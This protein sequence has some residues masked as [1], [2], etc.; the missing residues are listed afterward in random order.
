MHTIRR[1]FVLLIVFLH[2]ILPGQIL[3]IQSD[4]LWFPPT[5]YGDTLTG[6][7]TIVN[8]STTAIQLK[9]VEIGKA[10][11]DLAFT[12]SNIPTSIPPG[13]SQLIVRFHPLNDIYYRVP[14]ILRTES[15]GGD[16]TVLLTGQGKFFS[17]IG[18]FTENKT[19]LALKQALASYQS[20]HT[21]L[22]YNGARDLM[23]SKLDNING[24]VTCLYTGRM[25]QFNTRAGATA[26]NF[27]AEHVFPQSFFNQNEPMRSDL[28]HLYSTDETAN[29]I[30]SNYPYGIITG[31]PSWQNN[32][33]KLQNGVFEPR[34]SAKGRVAR[35]LLYFVVRYQDYS[36]FV[37]PQ[38][39]LLRNWH[40]QHLPDAMD[41]R[42]DSI[43]AVHQG[44]HNVFIKYPF[45]LHRINSLTGQA[46]FP[47]TKNFRWSSDTLFTKTSFTSTYFSLWN[48]GYYPLS[49]DSIKISA[50]GSQFT[51]SQLTVPAFSAARC[52]L[53]L[54]ANLPTGVYSATAYSGTIQ[55]SLYFYHTFQ[56][57]LEEFPEQVEIHLYPNPADEHLYIETS[58]DVKSLQILT[59]FGQKV[60]EGDFQPY[61]SIK[62]LPAGNYIL[63]IKDFFGNQFAK[64]FVVTHS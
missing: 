36:N 62:N 35:A 47:N 61:L 49:I 25:A 15:A 43:I 24:W 20:N 38:E 41:R 42:R 16:Y 32:G 64:K 58:I 48:Q 3:T 40:F 26:N 21:N 31:N 63:L 39:N 28:N 19:G 4:S 9:S 60:F 10:Y 5:E 34:D 29:N 33:S 45:I 53:A 46:D 17:S 7:I 56:L 51:I 30:R 55:K 1:L 18:Q 6:S 37:A 57:S 50:P 44:K 2:N 52:T 22:G 8:Q 27:N 59:P 11:N 12:L 14:L 13:T 54:P 23:Y